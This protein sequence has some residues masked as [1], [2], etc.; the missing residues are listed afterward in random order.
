MVRLAR[1]GFEVDPVF[2]ISADVRIAELKRDTEGARGREWAVRIERVA[3][4]LRLPTL[5]KPGWLVGADRDDRKAQRREL[6]FDFA[7]L[8]ELRIAVGSPTAAVEDEQRA[9]RADEL[10]EIDE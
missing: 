1:C 2:P 4:P 10:R 5:L 9:A 3:E 8:A 7:Q 6:G